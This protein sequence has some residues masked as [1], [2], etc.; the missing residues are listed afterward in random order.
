MRHALRM[1]LDVENGRFLVD[2]LPHGEAQV[3]VWSPDRPAVLLARVQL[4]RGEHR[5]LGVLE[6]PEL[7]SLTVRV[8]TATGTPAPPSLRTTLVGRQITRR[9]TSGSACFEALP[10][11]EP[12]VL[13]IGK[14]GLSE[15]VHLILDPG[16]QRMLEHRLAPPD[17]QRLV[18]ERERSSEIQNVMPPR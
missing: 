6:I 11:R 12:L 10:P 16:E 14:G 8:L 15:P 5:S 13:R 3:R 7:A 2:G 18:T 1:D 9:A 4:R 17:Q